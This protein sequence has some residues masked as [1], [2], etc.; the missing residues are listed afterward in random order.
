MERCD[1]VFTLERGF[2]ASLKQTHTHKQNKNKKQQGKLNK[3]AILHHKAS[4]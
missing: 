3:T 2:G 4:V 1:D